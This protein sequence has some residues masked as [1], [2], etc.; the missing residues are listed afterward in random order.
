MWVP[1]VIK[2]FVYTLGLESLRANLYFALCLS[3]MKRFQ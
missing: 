1:T 3:N 2:Y